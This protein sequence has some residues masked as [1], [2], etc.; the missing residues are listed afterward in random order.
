MWSNYCL[1]QVFCPFS[2]DVHVFWTLNSAL[3]VFYR[4]KEYMITVFRSVGRVF[5][6]NHFHYLYYT[7][8]CITKPAFVNNKKRV[9][10]CFFLYLSSLTSAKVSHLSDFFMDGRILI[11]VKCQLE[12]FDFDPI[13]TECYLATTNLNV[14]FTIIAFLSRI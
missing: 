11:A 10:H 3:L 7:I 2:E 8:S 9:K 5:N 4:L 12:L 1:D 13:K 6:R 14:F